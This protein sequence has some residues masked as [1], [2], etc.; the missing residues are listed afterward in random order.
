MEENLAHQNEQRDWR[1]REIHHGRGTVPDHLTEAG[2]AAEKQDSPDDIDR[3]KREGDGHADEE[4]NRGAAEKQQ[5]R[6]LPGHTAVPCTRGL[7]S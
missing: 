7:G 6:K 1:Q 5:G 4:Q 2:I 3:D